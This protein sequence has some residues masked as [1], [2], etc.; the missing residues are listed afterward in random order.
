[1][2]RLSS[3]KKKMLGSTPVPFLYKHQILLGQ[4][5]M[6]I[7][8]SSSYHRYYE[9]RSLNTA[10]NTDMSDDEVSQLCERWMNHLWSKCLYQKQTNKKIYRKQYSFNTHTRAHTHTHRHT[11]IYLPAA[12][13]S[14]N[15]KGCDMNGTWWSIFC[16]FSSFSI[17]KMYI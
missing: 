13:F 3:V 11:R 1:M 4:K 8:E 6:S 7:N 9:L 14:L 16:F 12:I 15:S 5:L 17:N 10:A 2:R